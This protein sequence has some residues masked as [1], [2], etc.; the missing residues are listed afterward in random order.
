MHLN[1]LLWGKYIKKRLMIPQGLIRNRTSNN[2]QHHILNRKDIKHNTTLT[3]QKTKDWPM[4]S[5]QKP[6][7]N[8][9]QFLLQYWHSSSC[10]KSSRWLVRGKEN[11]WFLRQMEHISS[12][13]WQRYSV[14]F[15]QVN[16]TSCSMFPV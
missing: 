16:L 15:N 6:L 10:W 1:A 9:N 5:P 11:G 14:T 3:T 8:C 2:R 4:Q 12:L 7:Y 13:S